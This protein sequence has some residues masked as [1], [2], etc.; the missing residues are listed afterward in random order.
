MD[1]DKKNKKKW[2][3]CYKP[4]WTTEMDQNGQLKLTKMAGIQTDISCL[5]PF[6][7]KGWNKKFRQFQ[8]KRNRIGNYDCKP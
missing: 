8:L 3:L 7:P 6:Q 1:I 4:K 5:I 2:K